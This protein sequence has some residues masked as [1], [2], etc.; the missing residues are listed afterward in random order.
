MEWNNLQWSCP[1][2]HQAEY[3]YRVLWGSH[4]W[5]LAEI[6]DWRQS[7]RECAGQAAD[8]AGKSDHLEG[9]HVEWI[10]ASELCEQFHAGLRTNAVQ[11]ASWRASPERRQV[12]P[13]ASDH[14]EGKTHRSRPVACASS[15]GTWPAGVPSPWMM[16][17]EGWSAMRMALELIGLAARTAARLNGAARATRREAMLNMVGGLVCFGGAV[18]SRC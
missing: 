17:T 18:V 15:V 12:S 2:T 6:E 16:G 9:R 5:H 7:Q 3:L 13:K 1:I 8:Q 10:F 14:D 4:E 11:K